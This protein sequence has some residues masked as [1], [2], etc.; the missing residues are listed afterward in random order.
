[1]HVFIPV[2]FHAPLG[3]LQ[4]HVIAQLRAIR[5]AGGK[6]TVMA[7]S[8]PF[9]DLV[10]SEGGRFISFSDAPIHEEA[11]RV[12]AEA[13]EPF[14]LVHAHPFRARQVGLDV[15][16]R[17]GVPFLL[18]LH[19]LYS[20]GL[21]KYADRV[22]G[23]ITVSNAIRDRLLR[24]KAIGPERIVTIPN[25]VDTARFTPQGK[26]KPAMEKRKVLV[27][28]RLDRDKT[29]IVDAL[30][31]T[32]AQL[33]KC[34]AFDIEWTIAGD[35]TERTRLEQAAD[36]MEGSAGMPLVRFLGWLTEDELPAAYAEADLCIAPGRCALEAMASGT[37]TIALG[38]KGYVGLIDTQ[39]FFAGTYSNFGG[40]GQNLKEAGQ[41]LFLDLDRVIYN[42]SELKRLGDLSRHLVAA[43]FDQSD[44]D[45]RMLKLYSLVQSAGPRTTDHGEIWVNEPGIA[46][47]WNNSIW[48]GAGPGVG[49]KWEHL[50]DGFLKLQSTLEQLDKVYVKMGK[51]PFGRAASGAKKISPDMHFALSCYITGVEGDIVIQLWWIEYD[52][53]GK[54]LQHISRKLHAGK[55]RIHVTTHAQASRVRIA[56]R[57]SKAGSAV[58]SPLTIE[59]KASRVIKPPGLRRRSASDQEAAYRGE[60]L[61]FIFGP[62]RSGTTWVLRLL[63]EHPRVIAATETNLGIDTKERA[64]L[65]TNIFNEDR[66]FTDAQIRRRFHCLSLQN[67]ERVIVEKTP[68]HLLFADR[69]REVFPEAA[70]V[71]VDR[72]PRDIVHSLVCVGRD[73][74]SWWKG[75]P[76][77]VRDAIKLWRLYAKEAQRVRQQHSPFTVTYEELSRNPSEPLYKLLD[78]LG[79]ETEAVD[80]IVHAAADGKGIPIP[81]VFRRGRVGA[82]QSELSPEEIV[83]VEGLCNDFK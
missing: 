69:I 31:N 44:A 30:C 11:E 27:A 57:I 71:L 23:V 49:I 29:F 77:N 48:N 45:E 33:A 54:R 81:G 65:E 5:R 18:T 40:T 47:P 36:E 19:S 17:I 80:Q 68:I 50:A 25:G 14:D 24:E 7:P 66:P 21:R 46:P 62:P 53:D 38:S 3:G 76:D 70:F 83:Q 16:R 1:M 22:D 39:T 75:A 79:L 78:A 82:W 13:R 72:D 15:A 10:L 74:N 73:P 56:L 20:D 61:V 2:H 9:A 4:A 35:G 41:A 12:I 64:T 26:R 59:R 8:G 43:F 67:S 55:N 37:A 52:T 58:L 42:R 34:R 51:E 28:S 60:N 6:V 32:W 63:S